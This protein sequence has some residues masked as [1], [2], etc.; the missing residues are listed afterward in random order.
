MSYAIFEQQR[1]R[2]I[3]LHIHVVWSAPLL[4]IDMYTC[5]IQSLRILASFCSWAGL[6]ES[7]MVKSLR[8]HFFVWFGS[9]IVMYA[10]DADEMTKSVD[11]DQVAPSEW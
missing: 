4:F 10:K 5:Y 2:M 1:R 11:P 8:K 3:S 9:I 6:F 7:Y